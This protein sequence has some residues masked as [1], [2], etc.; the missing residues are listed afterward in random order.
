VEEKIKRILTSESAAIVEIIQGVDELCLTCPNCVG[1]G[2]VSPLGDE[3]EVRKWDAIILK[4]LGLQYGQIFSV[5]EGWDL[6]QSH[7][8]LNLCHRCQ[9]RHSCQRGEAILTYKGNLC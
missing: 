7:P 9:W 2:C 6:I 3:S 4:E 5:Q 8:A 1:D